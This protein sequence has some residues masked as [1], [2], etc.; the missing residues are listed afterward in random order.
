MEHDERPASGDTLNYKIVAGVLG[1][2]ILVLVGVIDRIWSTA[3]RDSAQQF[4]ET[5]QRHGEQ[6]TTMDT[7]ITINTGHLERA[8]EDIQGLQRH[9]REQDERLRSLEERLRR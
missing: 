6:I 8:K 2:F 5:D 4:R 3:S 7:R 1:S 9:N